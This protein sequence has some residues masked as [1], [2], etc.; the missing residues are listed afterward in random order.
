MYDDNWTDGWYR[1]GAYVAWVQGGYI[2]KQVECISIDEAVKL[3]EILNH[4]ESK[5][6]R[7]T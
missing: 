7:T 6:T 5:S 4:Y 1:L 3:L 2:M